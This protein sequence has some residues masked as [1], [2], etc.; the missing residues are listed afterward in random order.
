MAGWCAGA[1]TPGASS[2]QQRVVCSRRSQSGRNTP[3]PSLSTGKW[4]VGAT[5][6]WAMAVTAAEAMALAPLVRT[7]AP[8]P[9]WRSAQEECTRQ[10]SQW[11]IASRASV[12]G[13]RRHNVAARRLPKISALGIRLPQA[14]CILAFSAIHRTPLERT[15]PFNASVRTAV[16]CRLMTRSSSP[17]G[18]RRLTSVCLRECR[19]LR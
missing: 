8:P 5:P 14:D 12:T 10:R 17:D 19:W 1:T 6:A 18:K 3:V 9:I 15:E 2:A 13:Q 7:Y 4:S 11:A 16:P